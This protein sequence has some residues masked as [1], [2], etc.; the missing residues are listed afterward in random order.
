MRTKFFLVAFILLIHPVCFV[1]VSS[2]AA[3]KGTIYP[4]DQ[5]LTEIRD[6][7]SFTVK[8]DRLRIGTYQEDPV[9]VAYEGSSPA[10][11]LCHPHFP[12]MLTEKPILQN[13]A[14]SGESP[15]K[16]P[17]AIEG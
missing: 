11:V 13:L 16:F 7:V 9:R 14:A 3:P 17:F 10:Y 12:R 8:L 15:V 5:T 4:E 6:G 2:L 1:S